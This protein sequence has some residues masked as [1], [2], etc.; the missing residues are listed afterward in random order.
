MLGAI[1]LKIKILSKNSLFAFKTNC[2]E[3]CVLFTPYTFKNEKVSPACRHVDVTLLDFRK[4]V[5][6]L[7]YTAL[8]KFLYTYAFSCVVF[9]FTFHIL[10]PIIFKRMSLVLPLGF[11]VFILLSCSRWFMWYDLIFKLKSVY[12]V[13]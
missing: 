2:F 5:S 3:H 4:A 7:L 6:Y 10:V 1:V 11:I 13:V 8:Q 9:S 12:S